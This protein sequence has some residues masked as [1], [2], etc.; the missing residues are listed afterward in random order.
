M[1]DLPDIPPGLRRPLFAAAHAVLLVA[2]YAGAFA[3]RF[4]FNV[5]DDELA[6]FRATLPILLLLRLVA[7][8]RLRLHRGYWRY[9][10]LHEMLELA[11]AVTLGTVAFELVLA[12]LGRLHELS[13]A[14]ILLDWMLAIFLCGGARILARCLRERQSMLNRGSGA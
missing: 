3:L 8:E 6:L 4:D 5:P 2:A 7:F 12:G 14:V 1:R 9:T 10:G 11:T 13:R